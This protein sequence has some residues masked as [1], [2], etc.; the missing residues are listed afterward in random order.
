MD[1]AIVHGRGTEAWTKV[2][3]VIGPEAFLLCAYM[4]D[5]C[6]MPRRTL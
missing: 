4:D 3:V 5:K 6:P 2:V 1:V